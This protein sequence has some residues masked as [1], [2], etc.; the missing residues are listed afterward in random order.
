M[1]TKAQA[2]AASG[3]AVA[4]LNALVAFGALGGEKADALQGAIV[5]AVTFLAAFAIR[6]GRPAKP[7]EQVDA[8]TTDQADP[9]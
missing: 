2:A 8:E 1:L 4:A 6:S 5:A 9:R 7:T 3:L